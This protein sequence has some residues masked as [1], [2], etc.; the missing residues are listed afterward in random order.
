MK[1]V[2]LDEAR[3]MARELGGELKIDKAAAAALAQVTANTPPAAAAPDQLIPIL[4]AIRAQGEAVARAVERMAPAAPAPAAPEAAPEVAEE[5]ATPVARPTLAQIAS[6]RA[7]RRK[8]AYEA[9][10]ERGDKG[11]LGVSITRDG[12]PRMHI[13]PFR[14]GE[15]V[16][17]RNGQPYYTARQNFNSDGLVVSMTINPI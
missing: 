3:R 13:T 14:D 17:T 11:L 12:A 10:F 5:I 16:V 2:S 15:A 6:A 4:E 1:V 8:H 7:P 9:M